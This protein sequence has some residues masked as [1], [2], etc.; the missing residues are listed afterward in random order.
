MMNETGSQPAEQKSG[1]DHFNPVIVTAH[2]TV[3]MVFMGLV[4][5]ALLA[6]LLRSQRRYQQLLES[7]QIEIEKDENCC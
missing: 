6:A 4:A 1:V 5:L 3:G 2:N 7:L